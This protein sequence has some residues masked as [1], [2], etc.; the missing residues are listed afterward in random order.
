MTRLRSLAIATV[1]AAGSLLSIA[2]C[3]QDTTRSGSEPAPASYR[4][5][6][7][8]V[9]VEN[10]GATIGGPAP[11]PLIV[12]VYGDGRVISQHMYRETFPM[13]ALPDIQVRHISTANVQRLVQRAFDAGVP[14]ET[15]PG[16][17]GRSD[18]A[19]TRFTVSTKDGPR[20]LEVYDL[21]YQ[22]PKDSKQLTA[23]QRAARG[24]LREL[25]AALIDLPATL[26][27]DAVGAP[28]SYTPD[29]VVAIVSPWEPPPANSG[30][31]PA[32][33]WP[34]PA[35]PGRPLANRPT[36]SCVVVTGA[37]VADVMAAGRTATSNTPWT[38]GGGRWTVRLRPVLPD[39]KPCPPGPAAGTCRSCP[40]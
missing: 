29:A 17:Y 30:P 5:D 38:S 3:S 9:R 19:T 35:L 16:K 23:N 7:V 12:S 18:S 39:E 6:E 2:A 40:D 26:G 28:T 33:A 21:E 31:H 10:N 20:R 1:A 11:W 15:D 13:P 4:A 22:P 36:I 25:Y 14:T 32:I 24:L 34:G 37:A 8:A 27:P